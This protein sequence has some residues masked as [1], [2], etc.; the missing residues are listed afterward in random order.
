MY[1]ILS[2]DITGSTKL[3]NEADTSE[4]RIAWMNL[5]STFA[6]DFTAHFIA[7]LRLKNCEEAHLLKSLGD[8]LVFYYKL[9][10][11]NKVTSV[12]DSFDDAVY[13]Y[14]NNNQSHG[15]GFKCSSWLVGTPVANLKITNNNQ[16]ID[17][18]G[19]SMD[20]GFRISKYSSHNRFIVSLDLA[21][22]IAK[23]D[24]RKRIFYYGK[25]ILKGVLQN[26]E[27]PIFYLESLHV[28]AHEENDPMAKYTEKNH[29]EINDLCEYA[30]RFMTENPL[31]FFPFIIDNQQIQF[32]DI[33]HDY[34]GIY[35]KVI[36]EIYRKDPTLQVDKD[37][38]SENQNAFFNQVSKILDTYK[39][40]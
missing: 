10:H 19:P 15:I 4:K 37:S 35:K 3:K 12:L 23:N 2:V 8:E 21:Y 18:V 24:K 34:P 6:T 27:Y 29:V 20:I 30:E 26:K 1:I 38:T 17:F 28:N 40:K 9:I 13:D 32:G 14:Y 25:E 22:L 39:N 33:P 5:F 7:K 16:V 31:I 36:T 11:S